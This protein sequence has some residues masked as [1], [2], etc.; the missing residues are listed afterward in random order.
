MS[1][2]ITYNT[3]SDN[4]FATKVKETTV[5][6]IESIA[7]FYTGPLP[8]H[9]MVELLYRVKSFNIDLT[10]D[11][12]DGG[13]LATYTA[14]TSLSH[15]DITNV[16][17]LSE[18]LS[19]LGEGYNN[20]FGFFTGAGG[21]GRAGLLDPAYVIDKVS[22]YKDEN[23]KFWVLLTFYIGLTSNENAGIGIDMTNER[24][25]STETIADPCNLVLASGTYPLSKFYVG[26]PGGI[27]D[28]S[29]CTITATEW[30]EY[31]TKAGLPAWDSSTGLASNGGSVS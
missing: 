24:Y 8:I 7:S 9:A 28:S 18:S 10:A 22:Y 13:G 25:I 27:T 11:Y 6:H 12:D 17:E 1:D 16:I 15:N 31:E 3:N 29:S 14:S 30:W 19:Q 5:A 21:L 23:D 20:E 4:F 2:R 26:M